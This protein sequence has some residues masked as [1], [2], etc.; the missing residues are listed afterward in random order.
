[1]T[2]AKAKYLQLAASST[3]GNGESRVEKIKKDTDSCIEKEEERIKELE[4][5][6]TEITIKRGNKLKLGTWKR[7]PVG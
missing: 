3:V 4:K 7:G 2:N 1:M 5:K 6:I